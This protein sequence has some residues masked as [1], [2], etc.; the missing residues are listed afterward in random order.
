MPTLRYATTCLFF[1]VSFTIE[2][3]ATAQEAGALEQITIAMPAGPVQIDFRFC[4]PGQIHPGMP[5]ASGP[6]PSTAPA[7]VRGFY[8]GETEVTVGQFRS[9]MGSEGVGPLAQRAAL[10]E[11]QNP[12]YRRALESGAEEPALL[13]GLDDAIRFCQTFQQAF[14]Q[15]RLSTS[16]V[17]VETRQFRL[18]GYIEWQYAARGSASA[19]QAAEIRHFNRWPKLSELSQANQQKCQEVWTSIG[20]QGSFSGSQDDFLILSSAT[21]AADTEKVR[22]ILEEAFHLAFKSEKR[23]RAGLGVLRPVRSTLPNTWN[24]F[25]MHESVTEWTIWAA[26]ADPRTIWEKVSSRKDVNGYENSFLSGGSF[27]DVPFG[28]GA[29]NRFTIWGGGIL[30]E[31]KPSPFPYNEDIVTD[32]APGFRVVMERALSKD[33]LFLVR[34]SI[35]E[36]NEEAD[37]A[38]YLADSERLIRELTPIGS[39]EQKV[40]G[41][42]KLLRSPLVDRSQLNAQLIAV[43]NAKGSANNSDG[44]STTAANK[45]NAL[46]KKKPNESTVATPA[47]NVE[48]DDQ[49]YFRYVASR[50]SVP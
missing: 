10:F 49:Q 45:L 18:P 35:N 29:L 11:K 19:E 33:W 1:A 14:E 22:E 2:G 32:Q 16:Q 25:D 47:G 17:T 23:N 20:K 48:S 30:T 21:N 43:A 39:T 34:K 4:P 42:Y 9:V 46:L 31:G 13:V 28:P 41:F 6:G 3:D 26:S 5:A 40:I 12:E 44:A 8:I 38:S 24:I 36:N 15:A 37:M 50:T 7:D 27:I